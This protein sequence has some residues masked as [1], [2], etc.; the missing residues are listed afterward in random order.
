MRGPHT[1]GESGGKISSFWSK[2]S[3]ELETDEKALHDGLE[4]HLRYV[5]HGKRLSV[6][7]ER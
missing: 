4:P 5:L 6:F 7:K 1:W 3:N 2:R